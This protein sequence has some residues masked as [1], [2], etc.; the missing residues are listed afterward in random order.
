ML[1]DQ[2]VDL[3]G[4]LLGIVFLAMYEKASR[5]LVGSFF[6]WYHRWMM[7]AAGLFSFAFL[8]DYFSIVNG[9]DIVA[10]DV[11]H[12][13]VLLSSAVIF[14]IINLQLPQEASKYL[15]LKNKEEKKDGAA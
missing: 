11:I 9:S 13:L 7:I 8:V 10:L 15:D 3:L 6:K 5:S 14:V 2:V 4:V 12:N 1:L